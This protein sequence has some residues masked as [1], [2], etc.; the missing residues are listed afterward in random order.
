M[1]VLAKASE[2]VATAESFYQMDNF[3][4]TVPGFVEKRSCVVTVESFEEIK[5]SNL[6]PE[7]DYFIY[8]MVDT[9]NASYFPITDEE[10]YMHN[11]QPP[12]ILPVRTMEERLEI[13]WSRM[14][15]SM[16]LIEIQAAIRC[17][18]V[19]MKAHFHYPIILIP[20]TAE[21][22]TAEVKL[23][24]SPHTMDQ[25]S[26]NNLRSKLKKHITIFLDWWIGSEKHTSKIRSEFHHL[27]GL[28]ATKNAVVMNAYIEDGYGIDTVEMA[29]MNQYVKQLMTNPN[30]TPVMPH[31]SG[32][33]V[34]TDE[35]L[36]ASS[37]DDEQARLNQQGLTAFKKFRSW[38][39]GGFIV[40]QRERDELAK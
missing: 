30:A 12:S 5:F 7:T 18:L 36:A 31:A 28:Y 19:Q 37:Y 21:L 17:E 9:T 11:T 8:A 4:T 33:I 10:D 23:L 24:I 15:T 38:F 22:N 35:Q 1:L 32:G 3:A 39:K 26:I 34:T 20:T 14:D 27:E 29:A 6:H 13:E 16:R 40:R 25:D 2:D